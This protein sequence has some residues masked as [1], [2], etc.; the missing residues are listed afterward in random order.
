MP[1][2]ISGST[3]IAGVNGSAG[4]PAI[5]CTDTDSGVY[6]SG[7]QVG[8]S[9]NGSGTTMSMDASGNVTFPGTVS[10]A[11]PF[12]IR[13][14]LING[15]MEIAQ[16]GTS[17]TV[18]NGRAYPVDRFACNATNSGGSTTYSQ[19]SDAPSGFTQSLGV[20]INT[21]QNPG[22]AGE[23]YILQV[24]EGYNMADL[25][26]GTSSAKSI[27]V[28][29]WVKS[30]ITGTY[31]LSFLNTGTL[32]YVAQYTISAA[33]AWEYK[34]VTI[35]GPT[36]GTWAT[37]NGVGIILMWDLGSGTNYNQTAGSWQ[38][39]ASGKFR[40]TTTSNFASNTGA[41]FYLAG[42]QLEIGSIATPFERRLFPQE[43]AMCQRYFSKFNAGFEAYA[44]GAGN[45]NSQRTSYPVTMR[46][47]PSLSEQFLAGSNVTTSL[48]ETF[49]TNGFWF[50]LQNTS[51]GYF[52]RQTTISASAEL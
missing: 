42:T 48:L 47:N 14:K 38:V 35:S 21:A 13:N 18:T 8:F 31:A 33:N 34:T 6:F 26:W 16:R 43:F 25:G 29:F 37:T 22:A 11:T 44:P 45:N 39:T 19:S 3:G 51:A 46:A 5:Q 50:K 1:I 7:S 23:N 2:T 20:V 40:S 10:M 4:T 32:C 30:S 24:I 12:A 49:D 15:A 27:T 17:F 52:Y 28:S 41:T 9:S 36:T